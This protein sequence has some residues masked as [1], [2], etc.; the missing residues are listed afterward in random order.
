MD[1]LTAGRAVGVV[2]GAEISLAEVGPGE[3]R[4]ED[5]RIFLAP[6]VSRLD[7]LPQDLKMALVCHPLRPAR[8][9]ARTIG[10]V[11]SLLPR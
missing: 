11:A 4:T 7:A 9:L 3:V 6:S 1:Q 8:A 2:S 10:Q 5:I